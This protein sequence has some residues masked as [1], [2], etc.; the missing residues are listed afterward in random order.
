M[1]GGGG[2]GA[3]QLPVYH[4]SSS[5]QELLQLPAVPLHPTL[6]L[7]ACLPTRLPA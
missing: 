5:G 6:A 2:G 7:P 4:R 1:G 3:G